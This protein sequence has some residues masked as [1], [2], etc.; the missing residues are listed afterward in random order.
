MIFSPIWTGLLLLL[1][2]FLLL[3]PLLLFVLL[4]YPL[5]LLL[6][7]PYVRKLL[8]PTALQFSYCCSSS[9]K[10]KKLYFISLSF[11]L[12]LF[13]SLFPSLSLPLSLVLRHFSSDMF[14]YS[15]KYISVIFQSTFGTAKVKEKVEIELSSFALHWII[16][17]ALERNISEEIW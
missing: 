14:W 3:L 11:F 13:L 7:S 4:L 2:H 12:S 6:S 10:W 16:D 8:F 17:F 15:Q 1:L 5:S 9:T